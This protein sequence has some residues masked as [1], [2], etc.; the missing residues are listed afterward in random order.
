M[1]W[2]VKMVFYSGVNSWTSIVDSFIQIKPTILI[3]Y[4]NLFIDYEEELMVAYLPHNRCSKFSGTS[5]A[6]LP[7][8]LSIPIIFSHMYT[9]G[10]IPALWQRVF[11]F[12]FLYRTAEVLWASHKA[13]HIPKRPENLPMAV[14]CK[15]MTD[16]FPVRRSGD[17]S[18]MKLSILGVILSLPM[19]LYSIKDIILWIFQQGYLMLGVGELGKNKPRKLMVVLELVEVMGRG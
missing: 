12:F 18:T 2:S 7:M 11:Y 6:Q 4:L 15:G 3:F 13:C 17:T 1:S 10:C 19:V 14:T 5:S 9:L 8:A 16:S